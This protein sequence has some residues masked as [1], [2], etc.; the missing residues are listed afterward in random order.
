MRV[1]LAA[2]WLKHQMSRQALWRW[3]SIHMLMKSS[4]PRRQRPQCGH[5]MYNRPAIDHLR[6]SIVV[7]FFSLASCA[8][9]PRLSETRADGSVSP[10]QLCARFQQTMFIVVSSIASVCM[11]L[12]D[13]TGS[14]LISS[15]SVYSASSGFSYSVRFTDGRSITLV[16]GSLTY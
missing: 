13:C 6:A 14:V 5:L 12:L 4:Q 2:K 3:M 9:Q 15:T 11:K 8:C 7:S 16:P 10:V 1:L